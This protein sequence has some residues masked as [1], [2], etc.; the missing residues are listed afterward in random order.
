MIAPPLPLFPAPTLSPIAPP[1]PPVLVPVLIVISPEEPALEAPVRI[2]ISP[3]D[4]ADPESDEEMRIFPLE[5]YT[6]S[7]DVR[8]M[9][10]P[11]A[12]VSNVLPA[13]IEILPPSPS[14]PF[15]LDS[16]IP[17]PLPSVE[18]P[19][20]IATAPLGPFR[21]SPDH[22]FKPPD[23][24]AAPEFCDAIDT[25]PDEVNRLPPD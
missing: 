5:L 8:E 11:D 14:V 21:L 18:F 24:P 2:A 25:D 17:P 15:P 9:L 16:V 19:V 4:P 3:D 22:K 13:E 20:W 10:P 6:P 12:L 23:R 1:D 7:P